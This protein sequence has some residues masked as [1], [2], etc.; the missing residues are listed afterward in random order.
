MEPG[1]TDWDIFKFLWG[2]IVSV[3]GWLGLHQIGR[4]NK[5]ETTRVAKE[6]HEKELKRIQEELRRTVERVDESLAE[7]RSET[8]SA[9][10]R[11]FQRLDT[12]ADR[13]AGHSGNGLG[14]GK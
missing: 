4:I 3:L 8:Q 1:T 13:I 2:A 9:F 7:H 10:A 11:V 12:L 14:G 5:L 6:E